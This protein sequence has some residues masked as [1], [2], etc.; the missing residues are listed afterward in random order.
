[1]LPPDL[2]SGIPLGPDL[3]PRIL[4]G[5][6]LSVLLHGPDLCC[7][8]LHNL[9]W[10]ILYGLYGPN[11]RPCIFLG[12]PSF[13]PFKAA[14]LRKSVAEIFENIVQGMK[15]FRLYGCQLGPRRVG[16][17]NLVALRFA[18]EEYRHPVIRGYVLW[19]W[20]QFWVGFDDED[21]FGA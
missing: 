12:R 17:L 16:H 3:S 20:A 14:H 7:G 21:E 1:M 5:P 6:D 10:G 11:L 4:H 19:R 18:K 2:C 15:L 13:Y 9:Y 8:I